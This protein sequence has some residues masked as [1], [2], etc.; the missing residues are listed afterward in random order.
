MQIEHKKVLAT[1]YPPI[2]YNINGERFLMQCEVDGK[3]FDRVQYKAT[4]ILNAVT[5]NQAGD[6]LVD[7]ERVCGI[8]TDLSLPFSVRVKTVLGVLN[9]V[10]GLSIPY[11][12]RLAAAIGYEISISELT[13]FR[14][15]ENRVGD[16]LLTAD[17]IF[18]WQVNIKE[19][20]QLVTR[21]YAGSSLAGERLS[22]YQDPII[23][24]LFDDLKPA[25][26]AVRFTYGEQH[27]AN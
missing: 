2:S 15:G 16:E 4:Q 23:E 10:G 27:A 6:M 3:A 12:I 14:A 25:H 21:F 19:A 22:F 11:F 8:V 17:S 20:S 9:A 18:C 13:P 26:T 24:G 5:P 7:W 1:L